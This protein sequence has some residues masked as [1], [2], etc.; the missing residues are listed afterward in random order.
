MV[1]GSEGAEEAGEARG[2][3]EVR[4]AEEAER[5]EKTE[6]TEK[7]KEIEEVKKTETALNV[8]SLSL[9]EP[10]IKTVSFALKKGEI[11]GIYGLREGRAI[12]AAITG[13]LDYEGNVTCESFGYLGYFSRNTSLYPNL[14]VREN[15]EFFASAGDIKEADRVEGVLGF[16]G[17]E[18]YGDV[19]YKD[20]EENFKRKIILGVAIVHKPAALLVEEPFPEFWEVVEKLK[21]SKIGILIATDD[22]KQLEK[23]DRILAFKNG[24][25]F[26]F[27]LA[28]MRRDC[29]L[30]KPIKM[31]K[32][33][34]ALDEFGFKYTAFETGIRVWVDNYAYA[35]PELVEMLLRR[36]I[37]LES[38]KVE[39]TGIEEALE[40]LEIP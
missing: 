37:K 16:L 31:E 11:L 17:V 13:F 22:T 1:R 28:K 33:I 5:T 24:S 9:K 27:K 14:T 15:L 35:I 3:R 12:I 36:G 21:V 19:L 8:D 2:A 38:L 23:C 26:E 6:R 30:L 7:A 25:A 29:I 40:A 18:D 32:A 4:E 34:E 39:K 20:L 10:S